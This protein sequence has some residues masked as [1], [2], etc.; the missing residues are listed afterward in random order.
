MS[1]L[2][3]AGA[4]GVRVGTTSVRAIS[5]AADD[6]TRRFQEFRKERQLAR[7]QFL[8]E[9]RLARRSLR[10]EAIE[11]SGRPVTLFLSPEAGLEPFHASQVL[12]ARTLDEAGHA[13]VMLSCNGLLPMCTV[14]FATGTGPTSWDETENPTCVACRAVRRKTADDYELLEI[15]LESMLNA[16][17]RTL[18]DNVAR[19][20]EKSPWTA[21]HDDVAFGT[22]CLAE[23]L[24]DR[25]KHAIEE[26]DQRDVA[27]LAGLLWASLTIY[28]VL[29]KLASRFNLHQIA[30]FGEY[31]YWQG[32][33]ILAA[34]KGIGLL[35]LSHGYHRDID[36]RL[37]S[38]RPRHYMVHAFEQV[39]GW[40]NYSNYPI[41]P[42]IVAE[43]ADGALFRLTNQG[44]ASTYSPTWSQESEKVFDE[45]GL[46]HERLTLIAYPSSY[47]EYVCI[48][49]QLNALGF[50]YPD[51]PQPFADQE[52]WLRELVQWVSKRS[53]L[54]LVVRMH[55]RMGVGHRHSTISSDYRKLKEAFATLP[56][57][58]IVLWPES[59]ISSYTIAEFAD[60]ALISWSSMG[61]ELARFGVPIVAAFQRIGLMPIS[62]FIAFEEKA[63]KYFAVV[64]AALGQKATIAQ[65]A[66][67]FRWTH[68]L[69]W[70]S[71]IDV[72]DVV[73]MPDFA[74]IPPY[75]R[76]Q[77][78]AMMLESMVNRAD[79]T[80]L[81]MAR[82][83][84][85]DAAYQAERAAILGAITRFVN[86]FDADALSGG[87]QRPCAKTA[88]RA[89]GRSSSRLVA[90]L[91]DLLHEE[92][93]P[94]TGATAPSKA[95]RSLESVDRSQS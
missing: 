54:Q 79:V 85:S 59:K 23:V 46:S 37:L 38:I 66:E 7:Q 49:G 2:R 81:N 29:Q 44:G 34:R 94:A 93:Q 33:Q 27:L 86:F 45:L 63:D 77:Q 76:P 3:R 69:H 32:A 6:A 36:R 35:A 87:K 9:Q 30:Y 58:V 71:L 89:A 60:A 73:P 52:T 84:L 70:G 51:R 50:A 12:L 62:N 65:V 25:R 42:E 1:I 11:K 61:L 31:A 41:R 57:N 67:A 8:K 39:D 55:P 28:L 15:G 24:R 83:D 48:A 90:R 72:S 53:S 88:G 95:S 75:R 47:D 16:D 20:F 68:Y 43:I 80:Q 22:I 21:E 92:L 64:E 40:K 82:L 18:I 74:Q 10:L 14:K 78:Q 19:R 4:K 56:P 26:L 5:D 91:L 17:D 13:A